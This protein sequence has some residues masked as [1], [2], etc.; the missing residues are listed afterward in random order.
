MRVMVRNG[1]KV[2]IGVKVMGTVKV[3]CRVKGRIKVKSRF[4]VKGKVRGRVTLIDLSKPIVL[5]HD[6]LTSSI[7][8]GKA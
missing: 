1:V 3:K 4:K 7:Y 6:P 8:K 2:C 5:P